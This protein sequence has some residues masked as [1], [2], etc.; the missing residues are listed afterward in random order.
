MDVMAKFL[1]AFILISLV[2]I[3]LIGCVSPTKSAPAYAKKAIKCEEGDQKCNLKKLISKYNFDQ[4]DGTMNIVDVDYYLKKSSALGSYDSLFLNINLNSTVSGNYHLSLII[5]DEDAKVL[6]TFESE[7]GIK[8]GIN[9]VAIGGKYAKLYKGVFP[10]TLKI[11]KSNYETA[12]SSYDKYYIDLTDADMEVK[13]WSIEVEDA[14]KYYDGLRVAA[15]VQ[16]SE[17]GTYNLHFIGRDENRQQFELGRLLTF[18]RD[19]ELKKGKNKLDL[20]FNE[21]EVRSA[22]RTINFESVL[23]RNPNTK[24]YKVYAAQNSF[25]KNITLV[26]DRFGQGKL[27]IVKKGKL[28]DIAIQNVAINSDT[29]QAEVDVA[30]IGEGH[31]FNVFIG[32]VYDGNLNSLNRTSLMKSGDKTVFKLPGPKDAKKAVFIADYDNFV[33]ERDED[34][35]I[36]ILR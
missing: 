9:S 23:L 2:A 13:N 19:I 35:N 16:S 12:L 31:A 17:S 15:S 30:N 24:D 32:A 36:Y 33:D 28:P 1:P 21:P 29:G 3:L 20:F 4:S 25:S 6:E 14:T 26:Y 27:P 7:A 11:V 18:G 10:I 8:Q 22:F 5:K 34:N